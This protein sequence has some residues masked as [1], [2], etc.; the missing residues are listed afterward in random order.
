MMKGIMRVRLQRFMTAVTVG[1]YLAWR[2]LKRSSLGTTALIIFVMTLTFLNLVVVTGVLVGLIEGAVAVNR[3]LQTGD[4]VIT[5]LSNRKYIE[6]SPN[7][8]R[9]ASALPEVVSLSP[10]YTE[11]GVVEANYQTVR[12]GSELPNDVGVVV[13]GIDPVRENTTTGLASKVVEGE[14]LTPFDSD[15][16]LVGALRLD[17]Y[18]DFESASFPTLKNVSVGSKVRLTIGDSTRLYTVKGIVRSKADETDTRIFMRDDLLRT[19]AGRYDYS[20]NEIVI[21][22]HEG[23]DPVEV[24]QKLIAAGVGRYARVQT[25]EEAEPKFIKD[26]KN[27]F[28]LLGNVIGSIGLAVAS[29]TIFIV[30][31]VNAITRRKYIGILKGIGIEGT[32]IQISYMIQA[33]FY[34]TAG[35]LVGLLIVYGVLVPY[36]AAH[37]INFPFSDG[38]LVAPVFGTLIRALV[39]VM[40]TIVA[41]Y[42]PAK[43]I[44]RQN[45]LD[46]ILGRT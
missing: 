24:K 40:A 16:V 1:F 11:G 32:A 8:I 34:A 42:I 9:I 18:L 10:R 26:M 31:F 13:A 3:Q 6:N 44:V 45:T 43:L 39:L 30:I 27:T 28:A 36:F 22:L 33:V 15:Q 35:T 14:Y 25:A 29:I 4:L 7:I 38:I 21:K 46:A 19:I 23:V 20:V 2:Q 5:T 41:G 17:Q 37:P 12:R